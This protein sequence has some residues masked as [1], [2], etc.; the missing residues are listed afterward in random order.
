MVDLA[1]FTLVAATLN[2]H[3]LAAVPQQRSWVHGN[4]RYDME[5]NEVY[6]MGSPGSN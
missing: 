4:G 2:A 3:G 6:S 1:F 5:V